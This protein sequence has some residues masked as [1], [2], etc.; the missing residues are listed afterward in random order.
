MPKITE[1][2][3]KYKINKVQ[4]Y[5]SGFLQAMWGL[6]DELIPM[7]QDDSEKEWRLYKNITSTINDYIEADFSEFVKNK[8]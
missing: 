6:K 2:R 1:N 4:E 5:G 7:R 8:E 3:L